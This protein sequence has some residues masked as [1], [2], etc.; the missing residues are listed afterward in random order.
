M[1]RVTIVTFERERFVRR[2]Q[3]DHCPVCRCATEWLTASQAAAL[4]QVRRDSVYRWLA[5]GRVHGVRTVG[6]HHRVCRNSLLIRG[7]EP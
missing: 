5:E 1:K 7:D 6:R 2:V 3:S 4:V